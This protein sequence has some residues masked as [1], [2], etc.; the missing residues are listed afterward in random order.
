MMLNTDTTS[1]D[2][3]DCDAALRK[4]FQANKGG[5]S[6]LMFTEICLQHQID[7]AVAQAL[8]EGEGMTVTHS[9]PGKK[10]AVDL[11]EFT[12]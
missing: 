9:K 7:N 2:Y 3:T 1:Q 5:M 12:R 4:H 11:Y 6:R 8:F 10:M